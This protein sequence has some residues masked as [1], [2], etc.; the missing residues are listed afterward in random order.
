LLRL[1]SPDSSVFI[2]VEDVRLLP[3]FLLAHAKWHQTNDRFLVTGPMCEGPAETFD[4]SA[5]SR[6]PLMQM[7]GVTSMAYRCCFQAI[8]AKSMSYSRLLLNDLTK[9]GD[10]QPFDS[11][12]TGWG[13]HET[14]FSFR[15]TLA[16]AICI[17]D[18]ECGTYHPGHS[19]RD[20][21]RYRRI[22]RTLMQSEGTADNVK[23]LCEKHGL[24]M[25]P[26]WR[27]GEP[28]ESPSPISAEWR[29]EHDF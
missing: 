28:I 27:V 15:A 7:S 2:H 20:E 12:M 17:Y 9:N 23:F 21:V 3:N 8:F 10:F 25:L 1:A 14:E 19:V 26:E 24:P 5:C 18:V 16:G 4:P 13:Y 6:W 11:L 29:S 22:D